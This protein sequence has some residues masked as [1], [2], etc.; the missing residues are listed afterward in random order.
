MHPKRSEPPQTVAGQSGGPEMSGG[1]E[2]RGGVTGADSPGRAPEPADL[3]SPGVW[4]S[5]VAFV[6]V[7]SLWSPEPGARLLPGGRSLCAA[8]ARGPA[9]WRRGRLGPPRP[10]ADRGWASHRWCVRPAGGGRRGLRLPR[11]R[12]AAGW[13]ETE[14]QEAPEVRE[15]GTWSGGPGVLLCPPSGPALPPPPKEQEGKCQLGFVLCSSAC[16]SSHLLE[17]T[18]LL[19]GQPAGS[20]GGG[21]GAALG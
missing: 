13:G 15:T 20:G 8:S 3:P 12:G 9:A 17:P 19:I 16:R 10:P 1:R 6:S 11:Q 21:L 4:A 2:V 7:R 18:Q 14:L 5:K